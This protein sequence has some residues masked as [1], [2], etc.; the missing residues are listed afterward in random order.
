MNHA[1]STRIAQK[2]LSHPKS[3]KSFLRV[4]LVDC[5][6]YLFDAG[7]YGSFY[8]FVSFTTLKTLPMSFQ[9]LLVSSHLKNH[10]P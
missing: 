4:L 10:L 7:F 3:G 6:Y 5:L 9:C 8:L 1:F 2:T